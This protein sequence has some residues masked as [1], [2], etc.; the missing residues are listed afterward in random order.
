[1]HARGDGANYS[2]AQRGSSSVRSMVHA[3]A[4]SK[5]RQPRATCAGNDNFQG[6]GGIHAATCTVGRHVE[7]WP[8]DGLRRRRWRRGAGVHCGRGLGER[9]RGQ[10][11]HGRCRGHGARGRR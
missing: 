3:A 7:R 10:G 9:G 8:V 4:P 1:M 5:N 2:T 11:P 6:Y